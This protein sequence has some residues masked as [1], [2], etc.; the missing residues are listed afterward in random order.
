MK[1]IQ[2]RRNIW[3][4]IEQICEYGTFFYENY[5]IG[6]RRQ[7]LKQEEDNCINNKRCVITYNDLQGDKIKS[8]VYQLVTVV[9]IVLQVK[10]QIVVWLQI[11][12]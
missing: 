5:K 8:V 10:L 2:A 12:P 11:G 1:E 9:K 4:T 3:K 7:L 6:G